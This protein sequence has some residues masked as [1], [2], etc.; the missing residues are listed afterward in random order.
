MIPGVRCVCRCCNEWSVVRIHSHPGRLAGER[1]EVDNSPHQCLDSNSIKGVE[2][3]WTYVMV[4]ITTNRHTSETTTTY[5]QYGTTTTTITTTTT[6]TTTTTKIHWILKNGATFIHWIL[7][8][9]TLSYSVSLFL[10]FHFHHDEDPID[11][12]PFP[13]PPL[14][15]CSHGSVDNCLHCLFTKQCLCG[16]FSNAF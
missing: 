10:N 4:S 8:N 9:S 3:E 2:Q 5:Y 13:S 15:G 6:T 16:P 12:Q 1:W 11:F 14:V 7:H